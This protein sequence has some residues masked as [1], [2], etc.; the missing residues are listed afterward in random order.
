MRWLFPAFAEAVDV[1]V[2][3]FV[4]PEVTAGSAQGDEWVEEA[5]VGGA[6]SGSLLV[7]AV[8]GDQGEGRGENEG[9][10]LWILKS[11]N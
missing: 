9:T 6:G 10:A 5:R 4:G 2:G 8:Q 1:F 7:P 11:E 3:V